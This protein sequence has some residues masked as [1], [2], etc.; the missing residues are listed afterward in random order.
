MRRGDK[1]MVEQTD[2][3]F[4]KEI[5]AAKQRGAKRLLQPLAQAV[6]YDATRNRIVVTLSGDV[7]LS[8]SPVHAQGLEAA[9]P[10]SLKNIELTPAGT[11]IHF[12]DIDADIYLPALLEGL[13]G[14]RR[15]MAS[16]MGISGGQAR[17]QAKAN[18]ARQN[19]KLG[20]RPKK[21]AA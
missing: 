3:G 13:L 10:T 16:T 5:R 11:G 14:S 9:S 6:I 1:Y 21:T 15:W 12:P 20:G 2:I 17:S 8:F 7:E 19:G 18:A 4:E